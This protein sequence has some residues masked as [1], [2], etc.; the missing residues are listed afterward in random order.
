VE[1]ERMSTLQS[2]SDVR[3]SGVP[4]DL[5]MEAGCD[6]GGWMEK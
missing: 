6:A 3:I 5:T 1:N 4:I 2:T